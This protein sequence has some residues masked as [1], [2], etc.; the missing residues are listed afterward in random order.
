MEL[1]HLSV[2]AL[3][4]T[5]VVCLW[6]TLAPSYQDNLIQRAGMAVLCIG[7]AS[8]VQNIFIAE[9]VSVDWAFVHCGMALYAIGTA[10]K[11]YMNC[12][13]DRPALRGR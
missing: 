12:R 11:Q 4:I 13:R 8:R 1:W 3:S 2:A 5:A 10:W 7:C 9:R 6:G